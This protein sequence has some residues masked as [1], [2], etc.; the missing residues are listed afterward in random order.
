MQTDILKSVC[1]TCIF[2][3]RCLRCFTTKVKHVNKE[4]EAFMKI[5]HPDV[6]GNVPLK[7]LRRTK[8]PVYFFMIDDNVARKT[9]AV[10]KPFLIRNNSYVLEMFPGI[11]ILTQHL[12]P[13]TS[14]LLLY[15]GESKFE[16]LL[17]EFE[18]NSE[19]NVKVFNVSL[20]NLE[21]LAN[22]GEEFLL[23]IPVRPWNQDVA[24]TVVGPCNR[25]IMW[26]LIRSAMFQEGLLAHGRPDMY[27]F[28]SPTLYT[29]L[30]KTP[31]VSVKYYSGISICFQLLFDSEILLD[32]VPMTSFLPWSRV[33][34]KTV[35]RTDNFMYL[36][37]I[38]GKTN[39]FDRISDPKSSRNVY[40]FITLIMNCRKRR[41]I[42]TLE[43]VIP[44]CGPYLI[45][46]GFSVYDRFENLSPDR[47]LDLFIHIMQL[48][49]YKDTFL[50][51]L[52]DI[53]IN[54]TKSDNVKAQDCADNTKCAEHND[55]GDDNVG[56]NIDTEEH[57][58]T[59]EDLIGQNELHLEVE[60]NINMD[61]EIITDGSVNIK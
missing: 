23:D 41:V 50:V 45:F 39:L 25:K 6:L 43:L 8:D 1:G 20:P 52:N 22:Q 34:K 19:Y 15:E 24:F 21:R 28:I 33:K 55:P 58:E 17:K 53:I 10:I 51:M 3:T 44:K 42:P 30:I 26:Y 27:V 5:N 35:A 38:T 32:D 29:V 2:F 7:Y 4:I 60:E 46:N 13:I 36:V 40:G 11:G 18:N 49:H 31:D 57:D 12:L 37:R 16:P 54:R 56:Y 9:V 14:N 59:I 47:L 61:E 48:P